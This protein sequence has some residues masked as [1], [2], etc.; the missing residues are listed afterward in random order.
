MQGP[1]VLCLALLALAGADR[2]PLQQKALH[3]VLNY[4]HSRPNVQLA[5]TEQA[6]AEATETALPGGTFVQLEFDI[7]QTSCRK[8]QRMTQNC[9]VKPG[10]RRQKCLACF[11]FNASNPENI[12]DKSWRCLSL[13]NPIFQVA[14]RN[15]EQECRMVKDANEE[16]HYH[17]GVFAFSRGLPATS[18]EEGLSLLEESA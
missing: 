16:G 11:K 9:P 18:P 4:F 13:Q 8:H 5:F 3:L 12:L 1:L 17:P 14:K 10:G 7:A 2:T 15:Q 6:V